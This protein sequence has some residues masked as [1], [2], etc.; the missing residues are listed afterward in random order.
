MWWIT[1]PSTQQQSGQRH[2]LATLAVSFA[3]DKGEDGEIPVTGIPI[4]VT[5]NTVAVLPHKEKTMLYLT[6]DF[7]VGPSPLQHGIFRD[8]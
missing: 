3:S 4:K 8:Y 5:D 2:D 1:G 7:Q 6:L